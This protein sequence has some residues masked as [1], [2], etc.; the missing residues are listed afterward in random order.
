ML[1]LNVSTFPLVG[2]SLI[3][4]SAGTGKTYTISAL[5][6]RIITGH[7]SQRLGCDKIL[8]VTFTEAATE[9]LR[10]RIR[11]RIQDSFTDVLRLL[12][13]QPAK[14]KH[15]AQYINEIVL[16]RLEQNTK[17]KST[18]EEKDNVGKAVVDKAEIERKLLQELKNWLQ[19]N[20]N[21]MDESSIFTIHGFCGKMLKRFAFDSGVMFSAEL[22]LDSDS[23]LIQA[24]EDIWRKV[25]YSLD[26]QQSKQLLSVHKSPDSLFQ[27]VRSRINRSDIT[28]LPVGTQQPFTSLW[29]ALAEEFKQTQAIAQNTAGNDIFDL[30][31]SSSLDKR[32][33]SKKHLPNWIEQVYEYLAQDNIG[34]L[35]ESAERLTPNRMAERSRDGVLPEHPLFDALAKLCQLK[36]DL[37]SILNNAW[38]EDIKERYFEILE[39]AGILTADDLLRLLSQALDS[40]F[41]EV[42]ADQI[43]TLYPV[44]MIDEFQDTDPIQYGIF[45]KIYP[46]NN[47]DTD[48]SADLES[49]SDSDLDSDLDITT[50]NQTNQHAL[51]MIGDPKQAIYA[52][53]G[54]DIFTYIKAKRE[55]AGTQRFTLDTNWRSHSK[56][57]AAVNAVF[58]GHAAPFVFN[59]DIPF[60][61]VKASGSRDTNAFKINGEE[62]A[63]LQ[64][65]LSGGES[66]RYQAQQDSAKEC[67]AQISQLLTGNASLGEDK[68]QAK[69]IAILVRTAKQAQKIRN[70]LNEQHISSVFLT[71]DS[72]FKTQEAQDL[73]RWLHSVAHPN[74][75][76]ALRSALIS[77]T[78]NYSAGEIDQLLNDENQWEEALA[79]QQ[80]YLNLW[81]KRGI[82]AAIMSWLEAQDLAVKLRKTTD[83]ERRLTNLMHLGDLLQQRSRKLRGHEALLRW[84]TEQVLGD[85][86]SGED[87]QLRLESDAN[88]VSIITIHKSKGLQYPLVFLPFL[89]D[90]S[91]KRHN[92]EDVIYFDN[93]D[94]KVKLHLDPGKDEKALAEQ[95]KLAENLRLLY[96]ALTRAEQGCFIWLKDAVDGR[97]KKQKKSNIANTALGYLLN[98]DEDPNWQELSTRLAAHA[99]SVGAAPEWQD[100]S[101]QPEETIA[102]PTL[103]A[104]YIEPKAWDNW[105]VSSY[106]Q[107]AQRAATATT[108]INHSIEV[109]AEPLAELK[110]DEG[111]QLSSPLNDY[112]SDST[113]DASSQSL[114]GLEF[115][116]EHIA[117]TF[118]K[119]ANAGTCLHD[120]FENW[121]FHEQEK[122]PELI[123][124]KLTYYGI[125]YTEEQLPEMADWFNA[126]VKTPLQDDFNNQFSLQQ[127]EYEKRL[128]EMEFFLP[129]AGLSPRQLEGLLGSS[130]RFDFNYL[131]GY[132]KGFIDLIFCHNGRYYVADYKSN[133]LGFTVA[134]YNQA[135]LT[136]A[137][138]EHAY[139]MQAW[140]YTLAL[141]AL[142]TRRIENYDPKQHLGGVY[143]FFMRGMHLGEQA[144]LSQQQLSPAPLAETESPQMSLLETEQ[145]TQ[146]PGVYYHAVDTA[147]LAQWRAIFNGKTA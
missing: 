73:L 10:G 85:D 126:M 68:V 127:L 42:L 1:P 32:S 137:M 103:T 86:N 46:L 44:A 111:P 66:N 39:Q 101:S 48:S 118:V 70:A 146:A 71:R 21:L 41:G 23:Y 9:E 75:E 104:A 125:N 18:E 26:F 91:A 84:F 142:L 121:D 128:D 114:Q 33:Y 90:D 124:S 63:P 112:S 147:K 117:L 31:Q 22:T 28:I 37:K 115:D 87:A 109:E 15:L 24:C 53:R 83:G 40:D 60:V 77:I 34:N 130:Q 95:A 120:I 107:L 133:H 82:M 129:I 108:A 113:A 119:G 64:F 55:L 139:D 76:R 29:Q 69:D 51:I 136:K 35:P 19:T 49:D 2:R 92:H 122:L 106:S 3:E 4:A 7:N 13:Q 97:T 20:L 80:G 135:S 144:P 11:Q 14:D 16:Q 81:L 96:V 134:D 62:T 138:Q 98:I 47:S 6:N 12:N 54:A 79:T 102:A 5:Y 50:D 56:L 78:Q 140:I 89:W 99:I 132:L 67:A 105:R 8:L 93:T 94:S 61:E 57:I 59:A 30:I 74:D 17:K 110:D 145:S 52:F 43:R 58:T 131:T 65:W 141:D 38:L 45:N 143:Y 116:P 88:L 123:G 36:Q 100:S 25:A 72:V 27:T